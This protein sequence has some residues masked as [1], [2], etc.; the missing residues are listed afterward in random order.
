MPRRFRIVA[1]SIWP[2][3]AQI[4]SGQEVLGLLL[5]FFFASAVNL[6]IVSRWIWIGAFATGV[7]DFLATLAGFSWLMCFGYTVWWIWPLS[8][9]SASAR[10]RNGYIARRRRRIC[11]KDDWS[12]SEEANRTDSGT[13]G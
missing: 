10:N 11:G 1:L 7:S 3:L 2:G 9:G 12:E 6:A 13:G 8:S 5:A 4:W